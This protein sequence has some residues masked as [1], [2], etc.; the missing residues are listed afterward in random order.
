MS[1][2]MVRA[3]VPVAEMAGHRF[4]KFRTI[5]QTGP[6][7]PELRRRPHL[8]VLRGTADY[9]DFMNL[10]SAAEAENLSRVQP[11]AVRMRAQT[12]DEFV[13]QEHFIGAG[14]LLRRLI[15]TDRLSSAIFSGPPG[16][17]K[18][19]L[20]H[21]IAART[22]CAF[23]TLHAAEA[24]VKDVRAV[25]DR[26]QDRVATGRGRTLLFL[27]EIHRFNKGQQD[28]LL[29]DVEDGVLILIGA[30][31]ENPFFSVNSPLISRSNL[32]EFQPLDR[33]NIRTLLQ[34]AMADSTRGL[35]SH[36][37]PVDEAA[38]ELLI[39]WS[40]GDAR[41][42]LNGLETAV[43]SVV[44]HAAAGRRVTAEIAAESLQRK[45]VGHDRDGDSHYD[46]ASAFI[47]SMRGSDP[48][49]A[50]YWLARMLEGG[51]DPRFIARRIVICASE[52]VGT[53]DSMALVVAAA[54]VQATEFVGLPEC[55]YAL[56]HATVY[57]A[58]APKSNAVTR[59]IAAARED[60]R[61][62]PS[63]PVPTALRDKSYAGAARLGRG[64]GYRYPHD[65][66]R[67]FVEQEYGAAGHRYYEPSQ[68][69]AEPRIAERLRQWRAWSDAARGGATP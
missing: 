38:I 60:S 64:Q 33:E 51:E 12:L 55:E 54:A 25:I 61:N 59:A 4:R 37:V 48:D 65:D 41:R 35:A 45:A 26:A 20:A 68:H 21:V 8:R 34:R 62:N 14:R 3:G 46:I 7:S 39:D 10:F 50:L 2:E 43:L 30:T 1:R 16:S 24:G 18:T 66:P 27:D 44:Q 17:G 67:G 19:T 15:E 28:A 11:L 29:K 9:T 32:F 52:D 22:R 58:C 31:T 56:A 69:G 42:A 13:G 63:R 6:N 40:D 23:E 47:K 49:A 53:A 57:V 36:G 5:P